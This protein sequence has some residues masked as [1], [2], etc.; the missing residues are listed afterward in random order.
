MARGHAAVQQLKQ[1][2]AAGRKA[3]LARL[4][5]ARAEAER[6]SSLHTRNFM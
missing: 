5:F 1:D 3:R 4:G 2:M 6:L